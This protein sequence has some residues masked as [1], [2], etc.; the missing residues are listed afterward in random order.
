MLE[1]TGIY[2]GFDSICFSIYRKKKFYGFMKMSHFER[3]EFVFMVESYNHKIIII[4]H[5]IIFPNTSGR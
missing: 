2:I 3:I 5:L 4:P 1:K